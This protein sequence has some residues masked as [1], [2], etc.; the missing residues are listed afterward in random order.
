MVVFGQFV[1]FPGVRVNCVRY[2]R[3][4]RGRGVVD[5]VGPTGRAGLKAAGHCDRGLLIC[6]LALWA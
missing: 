1:D 5:E 4:H 3:T 2:L 6:L